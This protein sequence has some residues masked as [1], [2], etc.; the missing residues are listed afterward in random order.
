M[1]DQPADSG[2][3]KLSISFPPGTRAE[4]K[5]LVDS[6]AT[7]SVSAFVAEAVTD[8]LRRE[9]F[10]RKIAALMG[11]DS[12]PAEAIEWA[13]RTLGATPEQTAAMHAKFG[14]KPHRESVAS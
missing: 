4:L 1:T 7:P 6:G 10:E 8:R 11:G 9:R 12:L 13:C 3:E 2:S 5:A 14:V